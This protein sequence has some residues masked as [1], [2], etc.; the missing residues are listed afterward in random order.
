MNSKK[1][2]IF[3]VICIF[4]IIIIVNSKHKS[5]DKITEN[6]NLVIQ[7]DS[8]LVDNTTEAETKSESEYVISP[9]ESSKIKVQND[10]PTGTDRNQYQ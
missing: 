9:D 5:N 4:M 3:L 10:I 1:V 2:F 6:T 8:V 7:E